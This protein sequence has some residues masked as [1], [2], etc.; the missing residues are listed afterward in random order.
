MT[1]LV[2]GFLTGVP[3]IFMLFFTVDNYLGSMDD[4]EP[5]AGN[6]FL[7][8]TGVPGLILVLIGVALVRSYI[9]D[10]KKRV[11]ADPGVKACPL[12]GALLEEGESVYCPRCW[13][14]LPESD[15]G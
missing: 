7:A 11:T 6:M 3:G 5:A 15:E 1:K 13:K 14:M 12:C 9:K 10:T 4:V 2:L 8:T